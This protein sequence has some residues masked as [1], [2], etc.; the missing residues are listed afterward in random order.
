MQVKLFTS[1]GE[2]ISYIKVMILSNI[3]SS[4]KTFTMQVLL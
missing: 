1:Y 2:M 4:D 3:M